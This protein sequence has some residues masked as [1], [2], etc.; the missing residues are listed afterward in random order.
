MRSLLHVSTI[1]LGFALGAA[2]AFAQDSL[3][4]TCAVH[5]NANMTLKFVPEPGIARRIEVVGAASTARWTVLVDG[6]IVPLPT[7][8]L[9]N[10]GTVPVH[11]GDQ[12]TFKVEASRHGIL[13][14]SEEEARAVLDFDEPAGKP[15]ATRMPKG[16]F[17]WGTEGFG[18]NNVL[19][20]ATVRESLGPDAKPATATSHEVKAVGTPFLA[21][22][23]NGERSPRQGNFNDATLAGRLVV[24]VRNG[25]AV[26]FSGSTNHGVVFEQAVSELDAGVW[27]VVKPADPF[28]ELGTGFGTF[29][30]AK[31]ARRTRDAVNGTYVKIQI[32]QLLPGLDNAIRFTCRVH[33]K[34]GNAVSLPMLGA[35]VLDESDKDAPA[36][37]EEFLTKMSASMQ[38]RMLRFVNRAHVAEDLMK[39]PQEFRTRTEHAPAKLH[40]K[41]SDAKLGFPQAA[42]E[43]LLASRPINGFREVRECLPAYQ[44]SDTLDQLRPVVESLGENQF[45]K[46]ELI[47]G[48]T[49]SVMHAALMNNGKV[50]FITNS[51][52]TCVWDPTAAPVVLPP[53]ATKLTDILYCSGHSFLSDGKLLA[54]GGGGSSPG[55]DTSMHAWKFNPDTQEWSRTAGNMS[56]QRW[57]PTAVTLGDEPGRVLV[58]AGDTGNGPAPQMEVYSETTDKF[59]KV[60]VTG[61]NLLF[62]PTYPGMHLLPAGEILHVPTGFDDCNQTPSARSADPTA[63]FS[64][65]SPTSGSWRILGQN[66]RL[67]GMSTLLFDTSAPFIQALVV[68]GGN[69]SKNKTAQTVNLTALTPAWSTPFPLLEERIHPNLVQLPDGTVFICGGKEMNPVTPPSGGRCELYNP[70]TGVIAEMDEMIVPRHYHSVA[71]LL[72]DGRVMA[73]G[74]ADDG[75]CTISTRNTIEVFSPPYLFKPGRPEIASATKFIEHGGTIEIKTPNA[76]RIGRVVLVRPMAVTHQ[77]DSEQ[78]VLQLSFQVTDADTIE[79][80]APGLATGA[81]SIAPRGHYMLFILNQQGVPSVAKWIYLGAKQLESVKPVV[82]ADA[83]ALRNDDNAPKLLDANGTKR[84]LSEFAGQAHMLVLIRGAFCKH[85]NSQLADLEKLIDP[86]T[87]P[88]IVITPEN[89]LAAFEDVP[90]TVL[91]DPEL[92][93]FR[94]LNALGAEP[95][96]GT[97]VFDADGK[98]LLKNIGEEP[99]ANYGELKKVLS[100]VF[101]L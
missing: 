94:K 85:C 39:N 84:S 98:C 36:S 91:A 74:G 9:A 78:R 83:G 6:N 75:G 76:A 23:W 90:F 35:L 47:R 53:S 43:A 50:V 101:P 14:L 46:W 11:T 12:I 66:Q 37:D 100:K 31:N 22:E 16:E 33:S 7:Q 24:K 93:V 21:W 10:P 61:R 51:L 26:T 60:T 95:M 13:F 38:R 17:D 81:N 68:G 87:T 80:Q 5:G 59:E 32:D 20:V 41:K 18:A 52:D 45:G 25:D 67:K 56:F 96:H 54:V 34:S 63:I 4:M 40:E 99:F 72:P 28:V 86:A 29:Y 8:T 44:V 49:P 57:Y 42:A 58:V 55:V 15:L 73:A 19:A 48:G 64:F 2:S 62:A 88:V 82:K 89:D 70:K 3:M 79:A 27:S 30:D 92:S 97:F 65:S 77:T 69:L 71:L 1:C